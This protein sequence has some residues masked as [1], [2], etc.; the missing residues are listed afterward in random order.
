MAAVTICS[1]FGAQENKVCHHFHY[2]PIYLP[3]NDE[4]RCHDLQ[5]QRLLEGTNKN[6]CTPGPRA[7][8]SSYAPPCVIH[9]SPCCYCPIRWGR[10]MGHGEMVMAPG[11]TA[12]K[13]WKVPKFTGLQGLPGTSL[14]FILQLRGLKLE[15]ISWWVEELGSA[16]HV[17]ASTPPLHLPCWSS[18]ESVQNGRQ[19][20]KGCTTPGS[21]TREGHPRQRRLYRHLG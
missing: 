1:D 19:T 5:W 11:H 4:T 21:L 7:R 13:S 8:G 3:W 15:I 10:S 16:C 12:E 18:L 14:N 2:S 17:A 9:W 6:L 20:W